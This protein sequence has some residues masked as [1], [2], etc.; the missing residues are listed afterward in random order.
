MCQIVHVQQEKDKLCINKGKKNTKDSLHYYSSHV[1]DHQLCMC[2]PQ[3][4]DGSVV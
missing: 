4:A 2:P 3:A 1:S